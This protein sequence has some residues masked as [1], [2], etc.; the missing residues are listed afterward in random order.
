[1]RV[2]ITGISGAIGQILAHRLIEGGHVVSGTDTRPWATAPRAI[3]VHAVDVRKRA[4]EEVFRI[5]RPDAVVHMATVTHLFEHS[6]D[7]YRINLQGTRAVLDMSDR[8]GVKQAIVVSRHTYYGAAPDSPLYHRE[9]EPPMVGNAF[10]ELADL[11]A[12]DLYAAS[13]LWRLP[14]IKTAVLRVCYALGPARSGTLAS[15]LKGRWV[16]TVLGFDPLFQFMHEEDIADAI[17]LSLEKQVHGVFNVAGP[18]PLPLSVVIRETG[19]RVA[20]VPEPMVNFLLKRMKLP[21]LPTGALQHIKFPI[22]VDN[23]AFLEATGFNFNYDVDAT[24]AAFKRAS[25]QG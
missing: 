2:L 13:A 5:F 25:A 17:R 7:R 22:L 3:K 9:D 21:M 19:R 6:E 14:H 10:P 18:E 20:Y 15:F 24:M 11:V 16:P 4:A 12:A 8:Y 23:R 1:M